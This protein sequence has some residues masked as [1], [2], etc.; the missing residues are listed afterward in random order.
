MTMISN[1]NQQ[2]I[3]MINKEDDPIPLIS[4]NK[5]TKQFKL[6]DEGKLFLTNIKSPFSVISVA[7]MYR[8]GKSYLINKVILNSNC[9]QNGF[10]VGSTV[11]ACTKGLWIWPSPINFSK[12]EKSKEK[13]VYLID[14]EGFGACDED[15]NHDFKIFLL[16]LI[17]S[18]LFIYNSMGAIDEN[19]IQSLSFT[20]NLTKKISSMSKTSQKDYFPNFLWVL[21]DFGLKL[22]GDNHEDINSN[23]YLEMILKEETCDNNTEKDDKA[24]IRKTIKDNFPIRECFTMIRPVTDEKKLQNIQLL[25]ENEMRYEFLEQIIELRKRIRKLIKPKQ[26]NNIN[27]DGNMYICLLEDSVNAINDGGVPKIEDIFNSLCKVESSKASIKAMEVF[28]Q[29]MS[30]IMKKDNKQIES[31]SFSNGLDM[32]IKFGLEVFF[33]CVNFGILSKSDNNEGNIED[34]LINKPVFQNNHIEKEYNKLLVSIKKRKSYYEGAYIEII[35]GMIIKDLHG[36]YNDIEMRFIQLK[37]EKR[38]RKMELI[39]KEF[40]NI[41]NSMKKYI[42][43]L[44]YTNSD[45]LVNELYND[46]KSNIL[47]MVINYHIEEFNEIEQKSILINEKAYNKLKNEYEI[48]VNSLKNQIKSLVESNNEMKSQLKSYIDEFNQREIQVSQLKKENLDMQI[49][50]TNRINSIKEEYLSTINDLNLKISFLNDKSSLAERSKITIQADCDKEKALLEQRIDHLIKQMEEYKKNEKQMNKDLQLQLKENQ[51][52][53]RELKRSKEEIETDLIKKN[54]LLNE[55]LMDFQSRYSSLSI[56]N[57]EFKKRNEEL[58]SQIECYKD[59]VDAEFGIQVDL[60]KKEVIELKKKLEEEKRLGYNEAL[61]VKQKFQSQIDERNQEM[62]KIR[63]EYSE[64]KN[65]NN[66]N[67]QKIDFLEMSLKE[68][69]EKIE[70]ISKSNE[71]LIKQYEIASSDKSLT[72]DELKIRITE[73][74]KV[75]SLEKKTLIDSYEKNI[76]NLNLKIEGL[77]EIINKEKKI[78]DVEKTDYQRQSQEMKGKIENLQYELEKTNSRM[79]EMEKSQLI[80]EEDWNIKLRNELKEKEK[81]IEMMKEENLKEISERN[82]NS[83]EQVKKLKTMFD[84]E[85]VKLEEKLKNEKVNHEK[86]QKA[87]IEDYENKLSE[88]EIDLKNEIEALQF[89]AS[90]L[91]K[92]Y[93]DYIFRAEKEVDLLKQ[94]KETLESLWEASKQ[95]LAKNQLQYKQSFENQIEMSSRERLEMMKRIE[96]LSSELS[97]LDKQNLIMSI[98]KEQI[99]KENET[100]KEK[101]EKMKNEIEK[102]KIE[103]QEMINKM[104][105]KLGELTEEFTIKKLE[106]M[107]ENALLKQQIEF[108]NNKIEDQRETYESNQLQY[109]ER[110]A[111]FKYEIENDCEERVNKIEA[112]KQESDEKII[113]LKKDIRELEQNFYRQNGILE[114]DKALLEERLQ[115]Q[116]ER[117]KESSESY[118]REIEQLQIFQ[119]NLKENYQKEMDEFQNNNLYL[120]NRITSL[121]AEIAE[122]MNTFSKEKALQDNRNEYLEQ[123][124]EKYKSENIDLIKNY[125]QKLESTQEKYL[126]EIEKLKISYESQISSQESK[127]KKQISDLQESHKN[128]Y[129][130]FININK[131]LERQLKNLQIQSELNQQ[132][133]NDPTVIAIKV[134]EL[135]E[136]QDKLKEEMEI[137]RQDKDMRIREVIEYSELEREQMSQKIVFIEGK[138]KESESKR[139]SV[140]LEYEKLQAGYNIEKSQ[141]QGRIEDLIDLKCNLEGKIEGLIKE[142]ERYKMMKQ[143]NFGNAINNNQV[144]SQFNQNQITSKQKLNKQNPYSTNMYENEYSPYV[145]PY[146]LSNNQRIDPINQQPQMEIY[147][148]KP[149][150]NIN[151]NQNKFQ[152]PIKEKEK[153]DL[154][155]SLIS[156]TN[157]NRKISIPQKLNIH[158]TKSNN[159]IIPNNDLSNIDVVDDVNVNIEDKYIDRNLLDSS[160]SS[161]NSIKLDLSTNFKGHNPNINHSIA[162]SK[163][164]SKYKNFDDGGFVGGSKNFNVNQSQN[165]GQNQGYGI[166][167]RSNNMNK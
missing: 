25:D 48:E 26:I 29:Q 27:I 36:Y 116:E 166:N 30:S 1:K 53:L 5:L 109:E 81:L 135:L 14:S 39:N 110:F 33:N 128:L 134:Q 7:G 119:K 148:K 77:N 117:N 165:M 85:K 78:N 31:N 19:A 122:K 94:N 12:D 71:G 161:N 147:N 66:V 107:R 62:W 136:F 3:N 113:N 76:S 129:M 84:F 67:K 100:M 10:Q 145:S 68:A 132:N 70:Y 137:L 97:G 55:N 124:R 52:A 72:N 133:G 32:S 80:N 45:S 130:E 156:N 102:E 34:L 163:V 60:L 150:L 103:M 91:R 16:S 98:K 86:K 69:N 9:V 61:A 99:E 56:E 153:N 123:Q 8:T 125:E 40:E 108:L 121:E 159:Q 131:E 57:S 89:E 28:D 23:E 88:V 111:Q 74:E 112:E 15:Q 46:F 120:K 126:K 6:T 64:L 18:S 138:L 167:N 13:N 162:Y 38:E 87:I 114:K 35:R 44:S 146:N 73:I 20:V 21:R 22:S 24:L 93:E 49:N 141:L 160:F 42:G 43:I 90:G 41:Y 139:N 58:L 4:F 82:V 63:E 142:I 157:T 151:Q 143:Y 83:E 95:A 2:K 101:M 144:Q 92:E 75:Y 127:Y 164:N 106:F 11:N 65:E 47:I 51:S 152:S 155:I 50:I 59:K 118:Q 105:L 37:N 158:Q 140:L 104:N 154:N 54:E 149:H 79:K 96:I 17:S 115:K